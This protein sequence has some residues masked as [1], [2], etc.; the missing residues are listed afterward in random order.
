MERYDMH[1]V[2]NDLSCDLTALSER[3]DCTEVQRALLMGARDLIWRAARREEA[4]D[5]AEAA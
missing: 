4:E 1:M 2:L 3:P 5:T